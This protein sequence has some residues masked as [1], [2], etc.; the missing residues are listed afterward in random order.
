MCY[1]SEDKV[2]VPTTPQCKSNVVITWSKSNLREFLDSLSMECREDLTEELIPMLELGGEMT[3][4]PTTNNAATA[5]VA[6]AD[7]NPACVSES[8]DKP[9]VEPSSPFSTPSK[10]NDH[11]SGWVQDDDTSS[12]SKHRKVVELLQRQQDLLDSPTSHWGKSGRIHE[13]EGGGAHADDVLSP[14]AE[15][16]G[17]PQVQAQTQ[18]QALQREIAVELD[19]IQR[20]NEALEERL[21]DFVARQLSQQQQYEGFRGELEETVAANERLLKEN[22]E[23]R[24]LCGTLGAELELTNTLLEKEQEVVKNM[25]FLHGRHTASVAAEASAAAEDAVCALHEPLLGHLENR[26]SNYEVLVGLWRGEAR[27][28]PA[29]LNSK[30][31][32]NSWDQIGPKVGLIVLRLWRGGSLLGMNSSF[33]PRLSACAPM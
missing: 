15:T 13:N 3:M 14:D 2:D 8:A 32:S 26:C 16:V 12:A 18:M 10:S 28:S 30:C 21:N 33:S 17:W 7:V 5:D 20:H 22:G 24:E 11:C 31:S 9:C 6:T 29:R 4:I 27:P 23:L 25:S 19:G 1:P